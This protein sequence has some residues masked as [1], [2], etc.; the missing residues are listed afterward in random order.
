MRASAQKIEDR[1]Q[2]RY[3]AALR[4]GRVN[5]ARVAVLISVVLYSVPPNVRAGRRIVLLGLSLVK[6]GSR[7]VVLVGQDTGWVALARV[8][9]ALPV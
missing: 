3:T 8:P 9:L 1:P 2:G 6:L 4:R 5:C 7:A